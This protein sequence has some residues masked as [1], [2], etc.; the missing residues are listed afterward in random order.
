M[1]WDWGRY[2][3]LVEAYVIYADTE[4]ISVQTLQCIAFLAHLW[5]MGTRG[6]FLIVAP[7]STMPNWIA[8]INR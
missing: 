2:S 8:E 3:L 5:E 7:L 1:R 4:F 6:P